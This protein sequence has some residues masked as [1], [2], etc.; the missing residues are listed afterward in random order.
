M[1]INMS[2]INIII[3]KKWL[4]PPTLKFEKGIGKDKFPLRIVLL[5]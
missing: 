4:T 3:D 2:I 1:E 5:E